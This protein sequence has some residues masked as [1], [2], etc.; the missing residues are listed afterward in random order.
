MKKILSIII[1]IL[2]IIFSA[3]TFDWGRREVKA[4]PL[5]EN[6]S[7]TTVEVFTTTS[8][9]PIF[10]SNIQNNQTI[11]NPLIIRGS[12]RGTWFFEA[13]FPVDLIDTDG[14]ILARGHAQAE[15]DWMTTDF[16]PFTAV[17]EYTK[18]TNTKYAIIVLSKDNPSGDPDKDQSIFIPVVLK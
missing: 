16:V 3:L 17:L 11:S 6:N 9:L 2:L 12:A 13:S 18:P 4:P 14:N 1:I 10:V 7:T 15:T 5:G 8:N